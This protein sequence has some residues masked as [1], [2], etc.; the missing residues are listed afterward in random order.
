METS[1]WTR[2]D[3][4]R[5]AAKACLERAAARHGARSAIHLQLQ[6]VWARAEQQALLSVLHDDFANAATILDQ[7]VHV[8]RTAPDAVQRGE[9][10][11]EDLAALIGMGGAC[12]G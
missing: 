4:L 10:G 1:R 3:R 9:L 8:L 11:G 5:K 12:H 6:A 2:I 7:A